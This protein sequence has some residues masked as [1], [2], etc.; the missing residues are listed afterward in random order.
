[1]VSLNAGYVYWSEG[2]ISRR[3]LDG[4]G[5]EQRIGEGWANAVDLFVDIDGG[6]IYWLNSKEYPSGG[7][8][9]LVRADLDGEN[10][11][12]LAEPD[13]AYMRNLVVDLDGN[14]VYWYQYGDG[15]GSGVGRQKIL[16][17]RLDGS[18]RTV[19]HT[20]EPVMVDLGSRNERRPIEVYSQGMAF[21]HDEN[22]LYWTQ[23]DDLSLGIN[24][25]NKIDSE[26]NNTFIDFPHH[27]K[28]LNIHSGKLYFFKVGNMSGANG[29]LPSG[30]PTSMER[31]RK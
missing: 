26:N 14:A 16:K 9:G 15:H 11:E 4:Q 10:P 19:I 23:S 22:L 27:A 13:S 1:M 24:R 3:R 5:S 17:A 7:F 8:I 6:K 21:D 12:L 2:H 30:P 29:T 28:N 25:L 31:E 18:Q 20:I